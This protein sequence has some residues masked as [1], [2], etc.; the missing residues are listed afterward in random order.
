MH[1]NTQPL[2]Q[3]VTRLLFDRLNIEIPAPDVDLMDNGLLDSLLLVN[4]IVQLEREFGISISID[5]LDL[6]LEH[7]RTVSRIATYI[8]G[9]RKLT[10]VA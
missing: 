2:T 3:A 5:D 1:Q 6:N 4:L 8:E 7:F 10:D 9:Q